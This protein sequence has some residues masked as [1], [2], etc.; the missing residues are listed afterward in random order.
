VGVF[1]ACQMNGDFKQAS[2]RFVCHSY[3]LRF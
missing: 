1:C 3:Y 2:K